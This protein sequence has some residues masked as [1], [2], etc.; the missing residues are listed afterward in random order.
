LAW[1]YQTKERKKE[2]NGFNM[3]HE[4][5]ESLSQALPYYCTPPVCVPDVIGALAV[6][7]YPKKIQEKRKRTSSN[8]T[9]QHTHNDPFSL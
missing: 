3:R 1:V 9:E 7:K 8:K 5:R 4:L 2:R 6:W